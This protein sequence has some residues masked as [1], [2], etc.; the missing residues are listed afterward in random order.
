MYINIIYIFC[1]AKS[2]SFFQ[3]FDV[4]SNKFLLKSCELL[5]QIIELK[6]LGT[7]LD[8]LKSVVLTDI[9]YVITYMNK[10]N[11]KQC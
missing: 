2:P 3:F 9:K 1:I 8:I 10:R 4:P 11:V 6:R 7:N 5:C